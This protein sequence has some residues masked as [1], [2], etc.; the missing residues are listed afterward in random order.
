MKKKKKSLAHVN[1]STSKYIHS[2]LKSDFAISSLKLQGIA[3]RTSYRAK[4]RALNIC[5][6]R[7]TRPMLG[8]GVCA[9]DTVQHFL[10]Y[11]RL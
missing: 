1:T 3:G 11:A 9:I 5:S 10:A 6:P 8:S 4:S 7:N 2:N